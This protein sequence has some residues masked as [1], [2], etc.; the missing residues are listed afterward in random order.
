MNLTNFI[1]EKVAKL[2][3]LIGKSGSLILPVLMLTI[4]VNVILR[5]V[6]DLG[7][8][9]LE[10][11]QWHLNAIVVMSCLAYTFQKD[12][13]IRVDVL[14]NRFSPT[15]RA[16]V[17]VIGLLILFLPFALLVSWHAW[18]IASYSWS[19]KEGSPMPSGLP[20]RYLIKGIMAI[21]LSLLALQ[22][23]A[24]LL[25]NIS[26][27]IQHYTTPNSRKTGSTG[28]VSNE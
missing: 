21:G 27:L 14:H 10:E 8:V 5:Y 3:I 9:E 24:L 1:A 16:W 13:H 28:E 26:F 2:S 7:L 4:V 12:E 15:G 11:L 17:E 23:V 25:S 6:F 19:L 20:A 18:G 22:G